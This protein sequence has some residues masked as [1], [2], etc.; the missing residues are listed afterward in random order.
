M[1]VVVNKGALVGKAT[2]KSLRSYF[3]HLRLWAL[4]A[5]FL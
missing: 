5:G 2:W 3:I 4:I 1:P